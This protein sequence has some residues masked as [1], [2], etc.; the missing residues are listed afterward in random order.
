[1]QRRAFNLAKRT[2]PQYE[3]SQTFQ[4]IIH[5]GKLLDKHK[6]LSY[7]IG[8]KTFSQQKD[9]EMACFYGIVYNSERDWFY[10]AVKIAY[11]IVE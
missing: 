3:N 4:K 5:W 11:I 1:M 10:N 9:D 6:D 7:P 2:T 8:K